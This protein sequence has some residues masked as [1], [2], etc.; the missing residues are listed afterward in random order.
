MTQNL[1]PNALP[2][3]VQISEMLIR[4]IAAGHL[5]DGARL[6]PERD[7]AADLDISVGTL[8]KAL[9]FLDGEVIAVEEIWLDASHKQTITADDLSDSLYHFYRAEL[10]LVIASVVDEIGVGRVPDWA[11]DSFHLRTGATTGYIERVSKTAS[12]EAA[13]F[14][15]TWFD[16]GKARYVSRMGKG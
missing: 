11:P 2:K 5:A 1:G 6:P 14:S 8:R 13:E 4:E 10:D 12:G 9:R 7:M 3:Y 15:R 16:N